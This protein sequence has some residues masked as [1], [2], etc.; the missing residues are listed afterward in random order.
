ML[1]GSNGIQL[2]TIHIYRSKQS[3]GAN[4]DIANME[5]VYIESKSLK[6]K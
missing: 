1:R 2:H 5:Y 3:L 4:T 6:S